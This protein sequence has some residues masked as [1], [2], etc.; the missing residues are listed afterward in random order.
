MS[1]QFSDGIAP[2]TDVLSMHLMSF[3]LFTLYRFESTSTYMQGKFFTLYSMGINISQHFWGEM[4]ACCRSSYRAFD[5]R[6]DSLV[7]RFITFLTLTI[8][9]WRN[10]KFTHGVDNFGK[11]DRGIPLK[12]NSVGG[13]M[14][15]TT[16]SFNDDFL[17]FYFYLT[18]ESTLFPFFQITDKA[19]PCTSIIGLEHK[20][21]IRRISRF[22]QEYLYQGSCIFTKMHTSLNDLGIIEHHKST[23]RQIIGKM[24]EYILSNLSLTI[25]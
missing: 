10:R 7:G 15:S 5:F 24:I 12:I 16:S 11:R 13:A 25:N 23:F 4:K 17:T 1:N 3:Y 19:I 6:I 21:I 20:F 18:R 22:K 8:K 14:N 2:Y 9:I